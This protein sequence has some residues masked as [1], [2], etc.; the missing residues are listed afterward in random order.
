[1]N[2]EGTSKTSRPSLALLR[3]IWAAS[4]TQ[5]V[6]RDLP[7]AFEQ[8]IGWILGELMAEDVEGLSETIDMIEN[9][10]T[11]GTDGDNDE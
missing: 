2:T 10:D 11:D 8:A 1:M 3:K 9:E 7:D 5:E 4:K 6:H